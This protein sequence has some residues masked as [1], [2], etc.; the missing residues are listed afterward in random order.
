MWHDHPSNGPVGGFTVNHRWL[1]A[2]RLSLVVAALVVV[3]SPCARAQTYPVPSS[4]PRAVPAETAGDLYFAHREFV[5]AIDAY[6]RAPVDA[7][8]LNKIGVA[9]HHLSAVDQARRNYELALSLR[10]NFPEAL[11]N[12]GAAYFSEK[13]YGEAVRLYR[14]ALQIAPDSPITTANLGTAYFAQGK[15]HQG[16]EAYRAAF[17]LDSSVFD[18]DSPAMI[19]GPVTNAERAQVDYCIAELFA[20]MH[21]DDHALDYLRKA[22]AAG[23]KDGKRLSQDPAFAD[24]RLTA[25]FASLMAEVRVK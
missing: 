15:S 5:E 3:Q 9:W 18:L 16:L 12:L 13:R 23:F 20:Q 21:N 10:P 14:R 2:C 17:S 8:T 19:D 4:A 22:F 6:S 25:D 1:V 24:L 7:A 11:N